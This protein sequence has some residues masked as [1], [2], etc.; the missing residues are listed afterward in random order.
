MIM[1]KMSAPVKKREIS[2]YEPPKSKLEKWLTGIA[3]LTL[4]PLIYLIG[5]TL[6]FWIKQ[7]FT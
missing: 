7:L 2:S 3:C 6:S 5:T 4:F 1:I